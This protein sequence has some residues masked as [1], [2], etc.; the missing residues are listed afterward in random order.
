MDTKSVH[1]WTYLSKNCILMYVRTYER[2]EITK[3]IFYLLELTN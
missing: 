3:N 2:Y 1:I